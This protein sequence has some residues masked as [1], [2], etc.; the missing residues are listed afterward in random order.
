MK[1]LGPIPAGFSSVDGELAVQGI[2]ASDLV[3]RA[4]DTPCFVYSSAM[5]KARVAALRV[6]M[7]ARL[8]IHYAMK[9]NPFAPLLALMA[10]LVDGIDI[11]SAGELALARAAGM[12]PAH[13]SFAGPGKSRADLAAAVE[14]GV[15]INME[16]EGE[17]AR[18]AELA[19]ITRSWSNAICAP[20]T[21]ASQKILGG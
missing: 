21:P 1:P 16:S 17:M 7:P 12:D 6:A 5:L 10:S 18:I 11:A 4:G 2:A 13:I 14:S 8:S 15:I 19:A 3:D 20:A 9:A